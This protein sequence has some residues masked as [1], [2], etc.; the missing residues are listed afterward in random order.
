MGLLAAYGLLNSH[1][2]VQ[3]ILRYSNPSKLWMPGYAL[4]TIP[5]KNFPGVIEDPE[6]Y[7]PFTLVDVTRPQLEHI[8]YLL[9]EEAHFLRVERPYS[10]TLMNVYLWTGPTGERWKEIEE[11]SLTKILQAPEYRTTR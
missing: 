6:S 11:T 7:A 2:D 8:D 3:H 5:G 9:A 4:M 1:E 10:N